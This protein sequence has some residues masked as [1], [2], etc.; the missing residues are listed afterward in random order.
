MQNVSVINCRIDPDNDVV[1][2]NT[3]WNIKH[4]MT[5]Q[6]ERESILRTQLI[7]RNELYFNN[8][9]NMPFT[10]IAI[11]ASCNKNN[12]F[13]LSKIKTK[14]TFKHGKKDGLCEYF[15]G[16]GQLLYRENF[17]NNKKDTIVPSIIHKCI[18]IF[19]ISW[20][21]ISCIARNKY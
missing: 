16:D 2:E 4:S 17:K 18:I 15:N 1:M 7:L 20:C 8:Q 19:N 3:Y 13:D 10:G 9:N 5:N 14:T 11:D 21:C 12:P 6:P